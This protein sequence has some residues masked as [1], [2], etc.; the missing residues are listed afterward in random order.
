MKIAL[1]ALSLRSAFLIS[2]ESSSNFSTTTFHN[3]CSV[4]AD[5]ILIFQRLKPVPPSNFGTLYFADATDIVFDAITSQITHIQTS[6]SFSRLADRA[7]TSV[8]VAR[9]LQSLA[10]NTF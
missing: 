10:Q 4:R 2:S 6:G 9:P 3:P 7:Y 8:P 1:R 5:F